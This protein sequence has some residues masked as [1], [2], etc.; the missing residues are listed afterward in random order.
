MVRTY[1]GSDRELTT[2]EISLSECPYC[3][4]KLQMST[5]SSDLKKCIE[6]LML[7]SKVHLRR[8]GADLS[9]RKKARVKVKTTVEK[10]EYTSV[11]TRDNLII[12]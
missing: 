3:A 9:E 10:K 5:M 8:C 2:Y 4:Q 6:Q 1:K 12:L 11:S 7:I